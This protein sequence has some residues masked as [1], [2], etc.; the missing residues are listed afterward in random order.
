LKDLLDLISLIERARV[1]SD[2]PVQQRS[3]SPRLIL[4]FKA[5]CTFSIILLT[6]GF[7]VFCLQVIKIEISHTRSCPED[8]F[9]FRLD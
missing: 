2:V 4:N 6:G 9:T 5:I 7:V 3:V 8:N 1:F